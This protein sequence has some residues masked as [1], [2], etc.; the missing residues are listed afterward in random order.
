MV[1]LV[2]EVTES[3]QAAKVLAARM[4]SELENLTMLENEVIEASANE[5]KSAKDYAA[6]F[7]ATFPA[8]AT[9]FAW[10]DAKKS[11]K[12]D[13]GQWVWASRTRIVEALD[14]SGHSNPDQVWYRIKKASAFYKAAEK[15][16]KAEV[17]L[18]EKREKNARENL[19]L[20]IE[21]NDA[22]GIAIARNHCEY[23]GLEISE[24]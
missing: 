12:S 7:D 21:D 20:A 1:K 8:G 19:R 11:H 2:K 22:G 3:Q 4:A 23:L 15:A 5:G 24:K 6:Y 14:K 9:P 10:C 16:E 13:F 17:S 18:T